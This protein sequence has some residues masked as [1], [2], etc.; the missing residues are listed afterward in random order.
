MIVD[1]SKTTQEIT[2]YWLVCSILFSSPLQI[3]RSTTVSKM[4][5]SQLKTIFVITLIFVDLKELCEC[6]GLQ[7]NSL[8]I[9]RYSNCPDDEKNSAH[10]EG[11]IIKTGRNKFTIDSNFTVTEVMKD[12]I[13]V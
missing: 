2:Q 10:F 13:K 3:N 12:P 9:N 7:P 6:F 8:T 1:T 5:A 4:T 11:T